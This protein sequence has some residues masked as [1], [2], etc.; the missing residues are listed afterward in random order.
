VDP[1]EK[2]GNGPVSGQGWLR[3]FDNPLFR[4]FFSGVVPR[5]FAALHHPNYRLFWFGSMVSLVGTWMQ[6]IARGWLIL[7]LSNSPFLV[8]LESTVAWLPAWLVSLPAGVLADR[9]NKRNLMIV[10]QSILAVLAMVLAILTLS[11]MVNIYHILVVSALT[12][13]VVAADAPVRHSIMPEL[14]GKKDLLNAIALN[15]VVFNG[16]RIIGPSIAGLVLGIIGAG[17]CFAINSVSFLAIII[18]LSFVKLQPVD[19]PKETEG[20]WLRIANGLRF[21]KGHGDIRVLMVMAAVYASFGICYM[22]MMPV[23]A[24][25]VF[26]AGPGGYGIMMAGLGVG[27]VGGLLTIATLGRTR[28]KGRILVLGTLGLGLLL[29][30]YSL[31]RN[32]HAALALLVGM[33]FSQSMVM[34]LT[35]TLI[36]TVCP[37][38]MRGRVMSIFT[39]SFLGMFPLGSLLAGAVAQKWGAPAATLLGGC[40]VLVSLLVVNLAQPHI[41]RL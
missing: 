35:N 27:A 14:V 11:G 2:T 24:R 6:N 1:P 12:G 30:A 40:V 21:V 15:G 5:T 18:A 34:S 22:P 8:G 29:L 3:P 20:V 9:F 26:H 13:F 37:D 33:G 39:M 28:H 17:G 25:D 38:H 4:W 23:F 16:A 32:F 31:V 41:R 36:Q 7:E 19:R 10:S